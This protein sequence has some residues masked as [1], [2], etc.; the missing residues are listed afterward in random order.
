MKPELL[1]SII[2]KCLVDELARRLRDITERCI[3]VLVMN[4]LE[5]QIYEY[6]EKCSNDMEGRKD[7]IGVKVNKRYIEK[8]KDIINYRVNEYPIQITEIIMVKRRKVNSSALRS[9]LKLL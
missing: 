9:L 7:Y 4:Q 3:I 1:K 5:S 2:K 6:F 8:A